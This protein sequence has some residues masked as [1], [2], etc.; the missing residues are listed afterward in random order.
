MHKGPSR[1]GERDAHREVEDLA[2]AGEQGKAVL[3]EDAPGMRATSVLIYRE[4]EGGK[5][6]KRPPQRGRGESDWNIHS[7]R[8]GR[9]ARPV[10]VE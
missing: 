3:K 4:D 2:G 1:P 5:H 8:T 10:D 9:R 7:G 6:W